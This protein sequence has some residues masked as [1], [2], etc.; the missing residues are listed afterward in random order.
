MIRYSELL[1]KMKTV[2]PEVWE[3]TRAL[4]RVPKVTVQLALIIELPL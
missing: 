1:C 4:L 3:M 2:F